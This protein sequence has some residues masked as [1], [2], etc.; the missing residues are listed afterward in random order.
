M[1][2]NIL[3]PIDGSAAGARGLAEAIKLAGG[4]G[5]RIRIIHVLD[6]APLSPHLSGK[7]FDE[8][9]EQLRDYG[10]N[11]LNTGEA[12]VRRA[13]IETDS[14]LVEAKSGSIGKHIIDEAIAWPADL[15]IC[16]T[17]GR[18]GLRRLLLG[19][20]AEEVL[21]ESPVPVMLVRAGSRAR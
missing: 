9:F 15:I 3:V 11:L 6:L 8:A 5:S 10:I 19:S 21:R 20:D 14:K 1:Y 12:G 2:R 18:R 16:G 17:H 4:H 13:A 7:K